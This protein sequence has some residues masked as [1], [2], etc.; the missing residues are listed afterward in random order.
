M[1]RSRFNEQYWAVVKRSTDTEL[2]SP[3]RGKLNVETLFLNVVVI[4]IFII[5]L[6]NVVY[7]S[8]FAKAEILSY[9]SKAS[10]IIAV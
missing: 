5:T 9:D 4:V 7:C 3:A 10:P 6:L 1:G 8:S 2:F